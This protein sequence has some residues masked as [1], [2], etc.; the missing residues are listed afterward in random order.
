[1]KV[2]LLEDV[3]H[4]GN[5]GEIVKVSDGYGRNFL[6]P[7]G[8]AQ[9]ATEQK[10][11]EFAHQQ[12]MIEHKKAKVRKAAEE[13]AA[14]LEGLEVKI[15]RAVTGDDNRFHGSVTNANI[16]DAI[17]EKGVEVDRRK[18]QLDKPIKELGDYD[19][20]VHLGADVKA[21]VKVTVAAAE[22]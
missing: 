16:A 21:T 14:K 22:A 19:V 9:L 6:I 7:Q 18:I 3:A 13:V 15:L 4:V 5:M 12:A 2:I 11:K 1:M 10:S 17:S 20:E 8:L